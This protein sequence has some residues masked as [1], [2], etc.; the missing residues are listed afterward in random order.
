MH[1]TTMTIFNTLRAVVLLNITAF[2]MLSAAPSQAETIQ[3]AQ[4]LLQKAAMG[5]GQERYAAI[6]QL[7]Q[8][9]L[10]PTEVV[11]RLQKLLADRD[12]Q[13]RWRSARSLGDFEESAQSAAADLRKLLS[14]RD[15]VVQYQAAVALGRI[16]DRSDATVEALVKAATG[17]DGR[18]ARAAIAA[19]RH[20]RPGPERTM[21]VLARVL[22]SN[23]QS[24]QLYALEAIIERGAEAV[25][26]LNEALKRTQTA[27]LACAAIEHIGPDAKDTVPALT[28]LLGKTRHSQLLI[29]A[30][31]ALASIGPAAQ[32]AESAILPLLET[33]TDATVPVA[34]AYALGSIGAKH[35]DTPLRQALAKQNNKFLQMVAAWALAKI[36]TDDPQLLRQAID[37][38]AEGLASNDA[39]IRAAAAKG[40]Q[41]LQPPPELLAPVLLKVANDPDPEVSTNMVTAL[42]GLGEAVVPRAVNALHKPEY[43][44]FAL[45]VLTQLGPK[46]STAVAP[47]IELMSDPDP[48]FRTEVHFALAAI[49][50]AAAPA[51]EKLAEAISSDNQAVRESA[52]FALRQIGP[53]ASAAVPALMARTQADDSF[54]AL[55]SAWALASIAPQDHLVAGQV[56]P[57]LIAAL[58]SPDEQTRLHTVDALTAFVAA[59]PVVV[60]LQRSAREDSSAAVRAAAQEALTR[61]HTDTSSLPS[62]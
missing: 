1:H 32:S 56:I 10:E 4:Q 30:L 47:L 38:L 54:D 35:A 15:P 36:H 40:L 39:R 58:S 23:D 27:Y 41:A 45:R 34:A 50:P 52:L 9:R 37:K 7:G 21:A 13:V 26:L 60:A 29:Q 49:G 33:S 24:V 28:E 11:P 57:K 14:D 20:L 6:D 22:E 42:A 18:V 19:L 2:G 3:T 59:K 44:A 53:G 55:A 8:N 43:R 5:S 51:A 16:G 61:K 25:P 62:P 31:L 46:A 12:P 48:N 17:N